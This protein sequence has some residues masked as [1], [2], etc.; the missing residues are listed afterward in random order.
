MYSY[1]KGKLVEKNP[2]YCIVECGGIGFHI[3]ISLNTYS[4]LTEE[5]CLLH[6]H[7]SIRNEATTPVGFSIYGFFDE[8]ERGVFR[9]LISVSG[10]GNNTALLMLS[11]ISTSELVQAI[12][13]GNATLLQSIKGIGGKTA[14]RIV[15]DLKDKFDKFSISEGGMFPVQ[16]SSSRSEA[17]SALVALGFNKNASEKTLDKIIQKEGT[18]LSVERLVKEAL[19]NL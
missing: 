3:H 6:T 7:L 5:N 14:Q 8:E 11:S 15:V 4:K 9:K 12:V 17:L 13:A 1:I 2:A 18:A 10:V 19:K 16:Q